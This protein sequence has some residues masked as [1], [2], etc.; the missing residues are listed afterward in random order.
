MQS[1]KESIAVLLPSLLLSLPTRLLN[2]TV[3]PQIPRKEIRIIELEKAK[4]S[5]DESALPDLRTVFRALPLL[6]SGIFCNG[7][8][9]IG[10]WVE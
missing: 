7:W 2:S 3:S 1:T 8:R 9:G 6:S 10:V 5:G 4:A